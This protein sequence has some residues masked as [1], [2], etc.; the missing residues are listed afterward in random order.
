MKKSELEARIK[1]LKENITYNGS[2]RLVTKKT[3]PVR[4][5]YGEGNMDIHYLN[6][7]TQNFREQFP[8]FVY[9]FHFRLSTVPELAQ[10][11]EQMDDRFDF[12][13]ASWIIPIEGVDY[14]GQFQNTRQED[15]DKY[16]KHC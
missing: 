9:A 2:P 1:S 6:H 15:I 12:E 14:W 5:S 10:F 3:I 8:A 16:K 4:S 11:F 7:A 13:S